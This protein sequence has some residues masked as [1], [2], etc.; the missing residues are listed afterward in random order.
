M[1]NIS[2]YD[3][4]DRE[5]ESLLNGR[6]TN[7]SHSGELADMLRIARDLRHLPRPDFKAQLAA[8]LRIPSTPE[9]VLPTLFGGGYGN[10]PIHS[11]NFIAS[12]AL[13]VAAIALIAWSSVWLV[14]S[15][16]LLTPS[17]ETAVL[18]EISPYLPPAPTTAG[19]GGGGGNRDKFAAT[20]GALPKFSRSQIVPPTLIVRNEDPKLSA[21]PTV[22]V[23]P[24]VRLPQVGPLGDPMSRI[25]G[26]LSNGSGGGIGSGTGGGVGS[27]RGPGVGPGW[28][29]GIGG[30]AY[31][32]GGG[33]S[34]PR[35]LYNP[36][37]Q[38]SDEARKA[39]HQGIVVLWCV[40]GPDGRPHEMRVARS[41][42]MGLDEKAL[43]AVR[44]WRFEPALKDGRPVAVQVNI[45][46]NF[47][48]Y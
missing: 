9:A 29:G 4:L 40:I 41:L 46:V 5:V 39:K 30:G 38:Y 48:L 43:E 20:Q 32:V 37:P 23:P 16:T 24:E 2:L 31:R 12:F 19:G 36:D 14:Q 21:D 3:E 10:Y 26:P 11:T 25:T 13:H 42:G 8:D 7:S 35:A 33:V 18:T 22:V 45:E 44:T 17:V 27:G 15:R 47:R 34:A 28:G 1:S 6:A